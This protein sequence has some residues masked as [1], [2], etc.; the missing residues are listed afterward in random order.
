[1]TAR[2]SSHATRGVPTSGE[3]PRLLRKGG[4]IVAVVVVVAIVGCGGA[5]DVGGDEGNGDAVR[6]GDRQST[7]GNE[8]SLGARP[9]IPTGQPLPPGVTVVED[10][11][12]PIGRVHVPATLPPGAPAPLVVMFHGAGGASEQSLELV[13]SVADARG[14]VVF[15]PDARAATWDVIGGG[16][17]PDVRA[18]D[19]GL[20]VVFD[21]VRVEPTAISAAGFSDGASYALSLGLANGDLISHVAAF[22][23]GFAVPP[24]LVGKPSIFV[25]HGTD[26]SVLPIDRTSRRLVP[27]LQ[28]SGYDVRY[29]EFA[30]GHV[31]PTELV[32]AAFEGFGS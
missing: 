22:S 4:L 5:R 8:A 15:A 28:R 3:E 32:A 29:V 26:D 14:L 31:V 27:P 7:E 18:V 20:R 2:W 1:M 30:G 11:E 21:R 19:R 9:A 13:R 24:G 10:A 25:S 6:R 17:G 12:G 16:W 23:P